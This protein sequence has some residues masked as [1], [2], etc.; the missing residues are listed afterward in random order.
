MPGGRMHVES[1]PLRVLMGLPDRRARGGPPSHLYLLR[2]S[3]RE[4]GI[5]VHGFLYGGR[6]HDER[7]LQKVL[8]RLADLATFTARMARKRPDVV[9]LNSAFDPKAI[10]R[11]SCFAPIAR[12]F[13]AQ[14][15][16]KMHGA[17][18]GMLDRRS[19]LWRALVSLVI[20]SADVVCV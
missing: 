2:D 19:L 13:G 3:L 10:V 6:T 12:L 8:G 17:D 7:P 9:H 1:R 11:D 18:L 5:D 16:L 15:V 20:G 4:L 14:V